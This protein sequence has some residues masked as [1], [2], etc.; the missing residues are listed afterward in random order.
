M[1]KFF[2]M[3][4]VLNEDGGYLLDQEED[5]NDLLS[6]HG[7]SDANS[8]PAPIGSDCYEVRPSD[9]VLL[10]TKGKNGI[11]T[12]KG[13]QT[14]VG[15]LLSVAR[16]TRPDTV[17]AVH[18]VTRQ[19]HQPLLHDWKLAKRLTRYSK[20][21]RSMKLTITPRKN[22]GMSIMV[23]SYSD[24]DF[25]ADKI[26]R[27]SLTGGTILLNGMAVSWCAK[28]QGGLSLFTMEA[29]FVAAEVARELLAYAKCYAK[30]AQRQNCP[31]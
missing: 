29:E 2:G 3:R 31:F 6:E 11:P 25:T 1:S 10:E 28:K 7:L 19:T 27:K 21:T 4:V 18:I 14:L 15:T 23:E 30:L 24:A 5:I 22:K 20:D 8:T 12:V 9:G 17:F 16:C 26:D 13:F